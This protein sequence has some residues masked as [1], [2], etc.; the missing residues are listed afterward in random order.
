MALSI[1]TDILGIGYRYD[2]IVWKILIDYLHEKGHVG[3][4]LEMLTIMKDR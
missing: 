1:F 2:E 4:C 3:A